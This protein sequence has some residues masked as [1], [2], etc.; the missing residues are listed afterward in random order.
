MAPV[1]K[2]GRGR[3]RKQVQ[4]MKNIKDIDEYL[5]EIDN[6]IAQENAKMQETQKE[7]AKNAKFKRKK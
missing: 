1:K 5:K 4:D 7:L 6:A 3:P 2:D